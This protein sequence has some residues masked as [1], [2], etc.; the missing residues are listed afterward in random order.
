MSKVWIDQKLYDS[1]KASIS[2]FDRGFMYGDGVFETMRVCAGVVFMLDEHLVRLNRSMKSAW[3]RPPYSNSYLQ[4]QIYRLLRANKLSGAYVR[5]TV[6]RGEGRFGIEHKDAL[7]PHVVIIAKEFNSYPDRMFNRGISARIVSMAQNEFSPLAGIKSLNFLNYIM[8]RLEAQDAG[9][10]EAI[11][12]NTR[13]YVAESPTSNIFSVQGNRL[14]TPSVSS[15][16]LPGI[17]RSLVISLAKRLGLKVTEKLLTRRELMDSD[18]IF[19]TNTLAEILPVTK[20]NR[21]KIGSGA[22]GPV[23]GLLRL[24]YRKEV[25]RKTEA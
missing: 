18:E 14:V 1:D 20:V 13:G 7:R 17:T 25:I 22:P 19:L 21:R 3:I 2:I 12:L 11:I 23:T 4:S 8:A 15:G 10:D 24:S 16:A 5:L 9:A 6:T